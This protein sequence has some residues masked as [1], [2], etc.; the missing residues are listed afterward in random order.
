MGDRS[1]GGWARVRGHRIVAVSALAIEP[2]LWAGL[3][4]ALAFAGLKVVTPVGPFGTLP[5]LTMRHLP[6]QALAGFDP[7]SRNGAA[8]PTAVTGLDLTLFG[9][10]LD[11]GSGRGGA[12]I[13]GNDGI[14]R[15]YTVGD[16]VVPGVKLA[17]VAFDGVSLD[18]G[19]TREQLFLDQSRKQSPPATAPGVSLTRDVRFFAGADG[20]ALE[21]AGRSGAF[22]A[23]GLLPGDVLQRIDGRRVTSLAQAL[24]IAVNVHVGEPLPLVLKRRDREVTI[25]IIAR[26]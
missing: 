18:R 24:D 9:V 1:E 12:I 25:S 19:G 23:A 4:M 10:R 13:G 21:P 8:A 20:V 26:P 5:P 22:A 11:R 15:N 14:Q 17:A 7:F 2:G 6:P 16:T 3:G